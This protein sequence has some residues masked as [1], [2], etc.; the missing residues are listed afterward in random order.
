M[1]FRCKSKI[2]CLECFRPILFQIQ[3][4]LLPKSGHSNNSTLNM[5]FKLIV[6]LWLLFYEEKEKFL[7]G[8]FAV[9]EQKSLIDV[10][11]S[12]TCQR[13]FIQ[14]C[15]CVLTETE[16]THAVVPSTVSNVDYLA[17]LCVDVNLQNRT[18]ERTL[19]STTKNAKNAIRLQNRKA[20]QTS[21]NDQKRRWTSTLEHNGCP[22]STT[23]IPLYWNWW[24]VT[25]TK[26][27]SNFFLP[28]R[29]PFGV[30]DIANELPYAQH[31]LVHCRCLSFFIGRN[32]SQP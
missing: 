14:N 25:V 8:N 19:L 4:K 9:R 31:L 5:S 21:L 18:T 13:S 3:T 26:P 11:T 28:V 17:S 6:L 29:N 24:L 10:G 15:F 22:K 1:S 16:W 7:I 30:R 32:P 12:T 23:H 20:M 2:S 27:L